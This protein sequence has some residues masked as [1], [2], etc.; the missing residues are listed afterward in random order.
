MKVLVPVDGSAHADAALDFVAS[1]STLLGEEPAIQ[2]INVQPMLSARVTRA[3][4]SE[5]AKAYQRAQADE[6]LRPALDR[7]KRAGVAARARYALGSRSDAIGSVAVRGRVD[8]IVMG[9]RGHSGLKGLVFGSMTNAVLAACTKPLL[10]LRSE[11]APERDSLAVG[12]AVDGSRYG[13]AAVRWAIAHRALFG[14]EPQ[15]E[16]IHVHEDGLPEWRP[17]QGLAHRCVPQYVPVDDADAA[18]AA[19]E[20]AM[21][22]PLERLAKAGMDARPVRLRGSSAG[23][24]IAAYARKRRLDVLAM[25]SHGHG[26]F[27]ALVLGSVA[28]R[29]AAR[30]DT[31]LLLIRE[32]TRAG[33]GA[34]SR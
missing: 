30:C 21:A 32:A 26:T 31:P 20:K 5:E 11:K 3:V 16:L 12:I 7:L 1:R 9:S 8:L 25:G 14:A 22:I 15:I 19:F 34:R 13:L 17:G 10:V 4:G 23:D 24:A 2:L 33:A 6:V 29:V 27:K 18:S 28:M